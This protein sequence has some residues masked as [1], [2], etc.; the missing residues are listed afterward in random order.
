MTAEA[1]EMLVLW[2]HGIS[3]AAL[4]L[5]KKSAP[6]ATT[7]FSSTNNLFLLSLCKLADDLFLNLRLKS[8][9]IFFG[10]G[11]DICQLLKTRVLHLDKIRCKTSGHSLIFASRR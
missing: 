9:R 11:V 10:G 1:Q 5:T 8:C 3:R 4:L 6:C 2:A 7:L